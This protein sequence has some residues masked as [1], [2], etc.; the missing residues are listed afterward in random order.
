[1]RNAETAETAEFS[2]ILILL[3]AQRALRSLFVLEIVADPDREARLAEP[4][5]AARSRRLSFS[6][7]DFILPAAIEERAPCPIEVDREP[8][9]ERFEPEPVRRARVLQAETADGVWRPI[10]RQRQQRRRIEQDGAGRVA[11]IVDDRADRFVARRGELEALIVE[12]A[13]A[14]V[15]EEDAADAA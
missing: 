4:L 15:G 12:P 1:R 6:R 2:R 8:E 7:E 5:A 3:R 14:H 9:C 11:L 13:A 10:H